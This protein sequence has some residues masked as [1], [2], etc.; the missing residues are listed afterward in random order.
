MYI[1]TG[2]LLQNEI[3]EDIIKASGIS[4]TGERMAYLSGHFLDAPY[5]QEILSGW[6]P[7]TILPP[8]LEVVFATLKLIPESGTKTLSL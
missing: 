3:D 5:Q 1:N 2:R 6:L 7:V 8:V 4:D